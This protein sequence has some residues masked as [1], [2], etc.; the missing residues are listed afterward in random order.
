MNPTCKAAGL[1]LTVGLLNSPSPAKAQSPDCAQTM[2]DIRAR[3]ANLDKSSSSYWAHRHNYDYMF[4]RSHAA[5]AW[6]QRAD[7]EKSQAD[8]IRQAMPGMHAAVRNLLETA[9]S[10][11]CLPPAQL[12]AI[13]E[14]V[15]N[16]AR[17]INFDRFP[18]DE[19]EATSRPGPKK[20]SP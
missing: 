18:A 19:S 2:Q 10:Q 20:M 6:K 17:R 16:Q 8:P 11:N 4:G 15:T 7:N 5:P 3:V 13:E 14:Q 1:I 9:K 12:Q